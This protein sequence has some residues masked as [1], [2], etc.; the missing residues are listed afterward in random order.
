[1]GVIYE[2]QRSD[3]MKYVRSSMTIGLGIEVILRLLPQ[4]F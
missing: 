4:E 3:G 1:M 2:V